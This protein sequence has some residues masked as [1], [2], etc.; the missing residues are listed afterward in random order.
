MKSPKN[1]STHFKPLFYPGF[2]DGEVERTLV[3]CSKGTEIVS[4]GK[5]NE[6]GF[7]GEHLMVDDGRINERIL[8]KEATRDYLAKVESA[9]KK[10]ATRLRSPEIKRLFLRYFD[11][12]Q[13]N[14]HFISRIARTKLPHEAIEKVEE[15]LARQLKEVTD[16]INTNIDSAELLLKSAGVAHTQL[17]TYDVMPL[18]FDV[19]VISRFGRQYRELLE[20]AD[21]LMPLLESL[22]IEDVI[23]ER[24]MDMRKAVIRKMI[25]RVVFGARTYA[26]GLRGRM[27]ILAQQQGLVRTKS[28]SPTAGQVD[29][30]GEE[31]TRSS[32]TEM[33]LAEQLQ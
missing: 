22:C 12:M 29:A 27:N 20:K 28:D 14:T 13:L 7:M 21:Q 33:P 1:G 4:D 16:E 32:S 30:S 3:G 6:F 11:S 5:L 26:N 17:A 9:S 2:S 25:K 24:E 18:D 10:I 23:T 15:Q 19:K 31:E 8:R